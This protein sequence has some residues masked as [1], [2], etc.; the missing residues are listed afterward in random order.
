MVQLIRNDV[1]ASASVTADDDDDDGDVTKFRIF[2]F[3]FSLSLQWQTMNG[4]HR[5]NVSRNIMPRAVHVHL[6]YARV[7]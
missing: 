2:N 6:F 1:G 5:H 7:K 4:I 3:H